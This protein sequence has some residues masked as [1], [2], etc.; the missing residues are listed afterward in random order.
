VTAISDTVYEECQF[1]S[2]SLVGPSHHKLQVL[3]EFT[4]TLMYN[5][6]CSRQQ[7]YVIRFVEITCYSFSQLDDQGCRSE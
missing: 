1:T 4:A 7:V 2:R 5:Q 3:G 6:K